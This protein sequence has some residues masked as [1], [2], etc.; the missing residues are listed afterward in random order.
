MYG[1]KEVWVVKRQDGDGSK[2]GSYRW[3]FIR[4][5]NGVMWNVIQV[6]RTH[7]LLFLGAE[8][9]VLAVSLLW[10]SSV[11]LTPISGGP[12]PS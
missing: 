10:A 11:V 12:R 3:G 8:I 9:G 2:G 7:R 4:D 1:K 6:G 5:Y